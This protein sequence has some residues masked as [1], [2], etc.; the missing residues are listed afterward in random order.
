MQAPW[1][2]WVAILTSLY[3]RYVSC[4]VRQRKNANQCQNI[5]RNCHGFD[6]LAGITNQCAF[7][8]LLV[9]LGLTGLPE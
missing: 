8:C 7:Y 4:E 9:G 1:Q 3:Q 6:V 2:P 5:R